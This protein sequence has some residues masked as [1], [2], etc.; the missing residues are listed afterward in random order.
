[1]ARLRATF[2]N[3]H[4]GWVDDNN[5]ASANPWGFDLAAITVPVSLCFAT[6]DTR[7]RAHARWLQAAIGHAEV[8][9]YPGGHLQPDAVYRQML[10]WLRLL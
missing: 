6:R 10:G 1:M 2:V 3:S 9:E 4:D 7:A 8:H 5:V